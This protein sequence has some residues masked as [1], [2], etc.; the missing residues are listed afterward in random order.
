MCSTISEKVRCTLRVSASSSALALDDVGQLGDARD[1]VGL[2]GD[3]GTEAH[4]LDALDEDAQRP[5][6]DLEHAGDEA[7]DA[8]LVELVRARLLVLGVAGGDHRQHP[9]GAEHVVDQLDR[10]LL[11]DRQRGERLGEGDRLAQRQHRQCVRQRLIGADR[12]LGV[13]LRTRPLRGRGSSPSVS[14][15]R[16]A[17][18]GLGGIAQR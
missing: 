11:A 8:D 2:L 9:V 18:G 1:Q 10:A 16:H 13:E 4:A 17:P 14:P 6:G 5:V 12:V 3:V 15:D 7:D